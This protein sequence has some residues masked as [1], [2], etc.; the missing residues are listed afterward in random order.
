M[1]QRQALPLFF[2]RVIIPTAICFSSFSVLVWFPGHEEQS[3]DG[4]VPPPEVLAEHHDTCQEYNGVLLIQQGG[5]KAGAGTVFFLF[6]LNQL[7]YA[8]LFHLKP[9]IHLNSVSHYVYDKQVH[10]TNETR[11]FRMA[12]GNASWS[13][14]YDSEEKRG[15]LYPGPPRKPAEPHTPQEYSIS[16]TGVWNSYFEPV[17]DFQPGY[18]SSLPLMTLDG[19]QIYQMH[20]ASPWSVRAWRYATL[21]AKLQNRTNEAL[22]H[23][24][25]RQRHAAHAVV[26]T[27]YRTRPYLKKLAHTAN[28]SNDCLAVHVR[29]SDKGNQRQRLKLQSFLPYVEAYLGAGGT[30]VFL[31]TDSSLVMNRIRHMWPAAVVKRIHAQGEHVVRSPNKTGVF[32]SELGV[33]PHRTNVEVLTD[34]LAISKCQYFLHGFSAVS[35]AAIY[36]NINLHETSVNLED[37]DHMSVDEFT[38]LVRSSFKSPL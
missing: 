19:D 31:A 36:W 13:K 8:D 35:E 14:F 25:G 30:A 38:K 34:I 1:R 4:R 17:S 23:W 15:Y 29:H 11:T 26:S 24:L 9:W 21:P 22:H 10:G 32:D 27:Y 7:I 3:K 2:L 28:P 5:P 6:V 33:S 20:F 12:Y 16:G 18:C 37:P